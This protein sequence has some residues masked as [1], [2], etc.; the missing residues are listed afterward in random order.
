MKEYTV[1]IKNLK[2]KIYS[3]VRNVTKHERAVI[4]RELSWISSDEILLW[5]FQS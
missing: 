5:E 3:Y 1:M 2:L 4:E